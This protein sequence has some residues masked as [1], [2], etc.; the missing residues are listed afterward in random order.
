M[1]FANARESDGTSDMHL[2]VLDMH[3][4]DMLPA[5]AIFQ[6]VKCCF[7]PKMIEF[8]L[9]ILRNGY[10]ESFTHS[11]SMGLARLPNGNEVGS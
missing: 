6:E 7:E 8:T 4:L 10:F 5:L 2:Y 9:I 3:I 1:N 11:L